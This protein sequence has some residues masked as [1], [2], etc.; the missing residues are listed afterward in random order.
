MVLYNGSIGCVRG[1]HS[2]PRRLP[3][4]FTKVKDT[5]DHQQGAHNLQKEERKRKGDG[6][7]G[8]ENMERREIK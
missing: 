2:P 1:G 4:G 5:G 7:R 3:D 8:K 6:G